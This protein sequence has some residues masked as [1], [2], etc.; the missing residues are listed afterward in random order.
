MRCRHAL[1]SV[2]AVLLG[3]CAVGPNFHRPAEPQTDRYT[4]Q[5]LIA[6]LI[7]DQDPPADWW[8]G[9]GSSAIDALVQQALRAN[10]TLQAAEATLRQSLE[11]VAAQRGSYF[12]TIEAQLS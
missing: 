1:V 11:N 7:A 4:S 6:P 10:P 12:P 8:H 3:G 2:A 9:F 5:P